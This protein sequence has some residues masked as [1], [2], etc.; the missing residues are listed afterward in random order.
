[1]RKSRGAREEQKISIRLAPKE[2]ALT[3][4]PR[5][6]QGN[7]GAREGDWEGNRDYPCQGD[8]DRVL[9]GL[10]S[11][12]QVWSKQGSHFLSIEQ[13][14]HRLNKTRAKTRPQRERDEAHLKHK[15]DRFWGNN[16]SSTAHSESP[17]SLQAQL[18]RGFHRL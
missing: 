15:E 4:L 17:G 12:G 10:Q 2:D 8:G 5:D 14:S 16:C 1:M 13:K 3:G 9:W 18:G 6:Q 7:R 11:C